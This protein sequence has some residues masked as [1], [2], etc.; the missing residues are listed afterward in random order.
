[1]VLVLLKK[2]LTLYFTR[3]HLPC[4]LRPLVYGITTAVPSMN[5]PVDGFGFLLVFCRGLLVEKTVLGSV[6][7]VGLRE[8]DPF[9]LQRIQV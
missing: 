3:V 4:S 6:C 9:L 1:M 8:G 2:T 5:F 7:L